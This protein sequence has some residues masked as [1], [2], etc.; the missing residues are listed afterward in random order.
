MI[1]RL[2]TNEWNKGAVTPTVLLQ[3]QWRWNIGRSGHLLRH[4]RVQISVP[5]SSWN[6]SC[7]TRV[8]PCGNEWLTRQRTCCHIMVTDIF[9]QSEITTWLCGHGANDY[10]SAVQK[11]WCFEVTGY[12]ETCTWCGNLLLFYDICFYIALQ[13]KR[14]SLLPNRDVLTMETQSGSRM[15]V[16]LLVLLM[17]T[18]TVRRIG[19]QDLRCFLWKKKERIW[20]DWFVIITKSDLFLIV[21]GDQGEKNVPDKLSWLWW[22]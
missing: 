18:A 7:C 4:N 9:S 13:G 2:S 11:N 3:H 17:F 10:L 1:W 8:V 5:A 21:Y 22:W 12:I 15:L 16:N 20:V 14:S 19:K 6:F